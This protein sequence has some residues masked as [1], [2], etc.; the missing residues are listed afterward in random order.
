VSDAESA[1]GERVQ[2]GAVAGAVVAEDTL[3]RDAVMTVEADCAGEEARRC[4]CLLVG[5]HLRVSEA[6]VI[7]DG[8]MDVLPADAATAVAIAVG[9]GRTEAPPTIAEGAFASATLDPT[10]LLTSTWTSSPGRERS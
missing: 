10:E 8:D 3:D 4:G 6:A 5:K 9:V 2:G 1:A 7:V